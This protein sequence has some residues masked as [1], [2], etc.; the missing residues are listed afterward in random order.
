MSADSQPEAPP[1]DPS[2]LHAR[3]M[4]LVRAWV[5]PEADRTGPLLAFLR[6]PAA[7]RTRFLEGLRCHAQLTGEAGLHQE[8]AR[9]LWLYSLL[10]AAHQAG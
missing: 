4:A 6:V 7:Q 2:T 8:S 10:E 3:A 5:V 1:S 9:A